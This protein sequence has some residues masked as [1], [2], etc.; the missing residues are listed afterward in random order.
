MAAP[1]R[2]SERKLTEAESRRYERFVKTRESLEARGY[3]CTELTVGIVWANIVSL[4]A[5]VPLML[6]AFVAF[7]LVNGGKDID[8]HVGLP[9][10]L[11]TLPLVV[12]HELIHGLGWSISTPNRFA[13]IEFGFIKEYLTPYCTCAVP[14]EKSRYII[15][16][17]GPLVVLGIIPTIIAI[18]IGS[19][20]LFVV[21][22][23]MILSAGGDMLLVFEL[24]RHKSKASEQLV[25][26]HPTQAGCVVFER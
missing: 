9:A 17:L 24:L 21:G 1:K 14:L 4:L 25:L 10:L 11:A 12:V 6:I 15:G 7:M 3:K 16:A 20:Q 18:A 8:F 26:D 2:E 13:D 5:G 19:F 23:V 22:I